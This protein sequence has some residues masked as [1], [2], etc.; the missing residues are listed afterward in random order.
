MSSRTYKETINQVATIVQEIST[1]LQAVT[2]VNAVFTDISRLDSN[3]VYP[4]C[5][6]RVNDMFLNGVRERND[7]E[8]SV[9]IFT[10]NRTSD[11]ITN[12]STIADIIEIL[13]DY[14]LSQKGIGLEIENITNFFEDSG[15]TKIIINEILI[16]VIL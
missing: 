14:S 7:F 3:S 6:I 1:S 5:F 2:A 12:L 10:K 13:E 9:S 15:V 4:C 8:V 11:E 16:T